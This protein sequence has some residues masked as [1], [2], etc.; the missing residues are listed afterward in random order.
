MCST[1]LALMVVLALCLWTSKNTAVN[2]NRDLLHADCM[3]TL[4]FTTACMPEIDLHG[5]TLGGICPERKDAI[6]SQNR[7]GWK[8]PLGSPSPLTLS[9]TSCRPQEQPAAPRA[10]PAVQRG[11]CEGCRPAGMEMSSQKG[12]KRERLLFLMSAI[13]Q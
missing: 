7:K 10:L 12:I 13:K 4:S 8:R 1:Y 9:D 11:R 6:E 2:L 5:H 3:T